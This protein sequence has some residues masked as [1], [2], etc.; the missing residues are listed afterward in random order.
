MR[1]FVLASLAAVTLGLA[2][3]AAG[4][5]EEVEVPKEEWS[6]E[7]VF[8]TFDRGALQRGFQ[9]Y[10]DVCSACH[11]LSLLSYRNLEAIGFTEDQVKAIAAQKTVTDGPNDQGEMFDRPARPSDNFVPPFPNDQAAR[12]SNGGALPPDLSLIAYSREGGADYIHAILN[13]YVEPP[14]GVE[15]PAGMFYNAYFPGHFIAMPPPLSEGLV[16]FA[17]GTPATVEQMS[18]DVATFLTW[19]AE[20]HLEDRKR[21]GVKVVLFLVVFTGLLYASKRKIWQNVH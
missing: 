9:V 16:E 4:A 10:N 1:R 3:T 7:G 21:T 11:S 12:A 19:A 6:F 14:E 17:D 5:V 20:P 15:V 8:G 13:G 18:R 2:A